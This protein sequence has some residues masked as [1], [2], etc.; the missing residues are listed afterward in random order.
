M[1]LSERSPDIA[2]EDLI[3]CG[4]SLIPVGPDKKPHFRWKP[5]QSR[6]PEASE[7]ASWSALNPEAWAQV[8]GAISGVVTIDFDG[9]AGR[10]LAAEWNIRPHR[11]SGSGGLHLD[12][13][14]PGWKVSTLN[15]KAAKEF[16]RLG[17]SRRWW[18][19]RG[20]GA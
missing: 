9:E 17:H 5:F 4:R 2:L 3:G 13:R 14:H 16:G 20:L 12:V 11:V 7:I 15:A 8:T 6:R 10:E 1:N 19:L 18:L